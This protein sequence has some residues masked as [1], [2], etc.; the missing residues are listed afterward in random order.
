MDG[1]F[2]MGQ[3]PAVGAPN[4]ALERRALGEAE[5]AR[6]PRHGRGRDGDVLEGLAGSRSPASSSRRRSAPRSSSSRP[7]A[8][9]RRTARFTNTQ[10]LLQW[11]E[12]AVDPPGDCR[13]DAWF[14][15]H[16]GRRLK[17][18]AAAR[19]APAQRRPA[20][21]DVGLPDH[22]AARR[23][24]RRSGAAEINGCARRRPA[25]L[26][27][28]V[29][30]ARRRRIDG[31]RLLDLLRRH[32]RRRGVN[33]ARGARGA[34]SLRPRLGLRVAGG[35]PHPLQPRVGA[36]GRPAVERAQEARLV[37]RERRTSGPASTRR[38]FRRTKPP[39]SAAA[40]RRRSATARSPATRRSSCTPTASAGSG[41]RPDSRTVRCRRTTSRSNRRSRNALYA[42]QANP[43]ADRRDAAGQPVGRRRPIRDFP[44]VLTTYRL[45][46]HHTAG[47]MSRTLSHL[48]ELQPALFCEISPELAREV[49]IANGDVVRIVT[50]RGR[51]RRARA[52]D[53]AH[54]AAH[55]RRPH[56]PS[57]R[58][59]LALRA[60]R[61]RHRR[62][63]QRSD[64]DVGG[65]ERAH[66]GVEG[67][68]LPRRDAAEPIAPR[69]E[70]GLTMP[71][72][73]FFTDSTVCIGCKACEVACKEWNDVPA[74]GFDW[75]GHSYDNTGALGHSTW[76][77]VKFVEQRAR[78]PAGVGF[79][80][81]R[82]QALRAR[83]LSRGVSD[84]LDRPHRV[85]RRLR[86]AGHLQRLRLL[87]RLVPV[88]RD[89]SPARRRPRVQVHVLLRPAE[90]RARAGVR[91]GVSDRV[92]PVR[93]SRRAARAR[94][95][96]R[97][98]ARRARHDR[99]V[100]YDPRHTSVGGTHAI[101]LVRGDVRDFNLPPNPEVPTVLLARG[102]RSAAIAALLMVAASG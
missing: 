65:A 67:A 64:R 28:R 22:R 81:R 57:G 39:T 7:P 85:R 18:K 59:A 89:R 23:A 92:D 9:P 71:T 98:R 100:V 30:R 48:A 68:A 45:T 25:T 91:E 95:S 5:V 73:G 60:S 37:G 93:R 20:R 19:H 99:R 15:Y 78:R 42:Q 86:A 31:V 83:R 40:S 84:R 76:R 6:R 27:L 46:E 1:L 47:G 96:A 33:R 75:T 54:P 101:F 8:T 34:R 70:V 87:R 58:A 12:K 82:L 69:R 41:C 52:R 21:A 97:G 24:G 56:R 62:R 50:A 55:D 17:A 2:V 66:H 10:R 63:R 94:A 4:A 53:A 14:V 3:N 43:A 26:R 13:S 77:H 88:R 36:T 16:L 79:L 74:D 80:V 32:A 11:H 90:G 29:H 102:W 44:H 51:I 72:T 38:T 49:G 35:S 61:A